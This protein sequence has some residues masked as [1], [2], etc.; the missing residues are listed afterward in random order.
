MIILSQWKAILV[1]IWW[2]WVNMGWLWLTYDGTGSV[3]GCTGWYLVVL[4]QYGAVLVGTWWYQV[5]NLVL[6]GIE[7]YWVS[8]VLLC[9][10]MLKKLMVTSTN[11]PT[12][13]PTDQPGEYRAICLF[14]KLENRKKAEICNYSFE[15]KMEC[16][17]PFLAL[18][19]VKSH[20][21][22]LFIGLFG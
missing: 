17:N 19:K 14:R 3:Q 18:N 4:G 9:L 8:E 5:S 12:D 2:C 6:I 10:Y 16:Y 7:W 1:S 15:R 11:Q 20:H 22:I 13:Q 21:F